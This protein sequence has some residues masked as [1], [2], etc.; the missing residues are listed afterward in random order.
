MSKCPY[1]VPKPT[2]ELSN[3]NSI[4]KVMGC[5]IL[6]NCELGLGTPDTCPYC[7]VKDIQNCNLRKYGLNASEREV[8][9]FIK[10]APL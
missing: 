2:E 4:E 9:D 7:D 10:N 5:R 8:D 3:S 6:E 1:L